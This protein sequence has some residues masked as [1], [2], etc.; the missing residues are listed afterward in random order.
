MVKMALEA[1]IN[2]NRMYRLYA[3]SADFS[4][5][6]KTLQVLIHHKTRLK[7]CHSL[8]LIGIGREMQY[9][10]G[11]WCG[12]GSKGHGFSREGYYLH[13]GSE[14]RNVSTNRF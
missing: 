14:L 6:D 12:K 9:R 2:P 11:E 13:Y 4:E 5:I 10:L 3:F 1:G 7:D 8:L